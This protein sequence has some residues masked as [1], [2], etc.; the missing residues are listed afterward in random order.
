MTKRGKAAQRALRRARR[1]V[2]ERLGRKEGDYV[3]P[4]RADCDERVFHMP[5]RDSAAARIEVRRWQQGGR[6]VDFHLALQ[7]VI[8]DTWEWDTI[9]RVDICHGHA[10]IHRVIDG[11]DVPG[12]PQ[13]VYRLDSLEDVDE[14]YRRSLEHCMAIAADEIRDDEGD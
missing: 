7:L 12:D 3:P 5:V 4:E 11:A 6:M 1:E 2:T 8:W 14:A 10:H 13:H 9:T